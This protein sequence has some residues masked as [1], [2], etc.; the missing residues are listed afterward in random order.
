[1]K[2]RLLEK[3]SFRAST[4][5]LWMDLTKAH[6]RLKLDDDEVVVF[7]SQT[8]DNMRFVYGYMTLDD[9]AV[10][11]RSRELRLMKGEWNVMRLREYARK[12]GINITDWRVFDKALKHVQKQLVKAV[13]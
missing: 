2:F 6:P 3:A 10:V 7:L 12:A 9:G 8:E 4:K 11:L 13:A 1:M 5:T